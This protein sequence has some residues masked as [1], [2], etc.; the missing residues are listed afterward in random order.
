MDT[1]EQ[2]NRTEVT[3]VMSNSCNPMDGSPPSSSVHGILQARILEWVVTP[4]GRGSSQPRDRTTSLISPTLAGGLFAT[5]A[6]WEACFKRR[7]EE[8]S[9]VQG[10]SLPSV[11]WVRNSADQFITTAKPL[12]FSI[13]IFTSFVLNMNMRHSGS[14]FIQEIHCPLP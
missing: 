5:S 11:S 4:S 2:L 14:V 7:N 8:T 9:T 3:S 12:R 10:V 6:T 1:T 13:F